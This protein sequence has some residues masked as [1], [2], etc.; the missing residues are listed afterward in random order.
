MKIRSDR[1]TIEVSNENKVLF[2]KSGI[3]K[4]ELVEYYEYIAPIML[5]YCDH[6]LVSMHRFPN[7]IHGENF[8]Q[9]EAGKYFPEWITHVAVPKQTDGTVHYVEIDKPA[10]ILYLANQVC[11]PHIWLSKADNLN[12]PDRLIFDLDP[13]GKNFSFADIQKTAKEITKMLDACGLPSFYMLTGSRGAHIIVPLKRVHTFDETH[14]FAH[15]VAA[16]LAQKF[17]DLM[18]IEMNKKKRGKRIFIDWLRNSFGAT[19]VAPYAVRAHEGA[20]I[21][22]PITW[23]ELISKGMHAQKYTIKNIKKRIN[24]VG[25]IWKGMNK[26]A[27]SLKKARKVL[28]KLIEKENN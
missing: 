19:A 10:T 12:K 20:P 1:Y 3:T 14:D 6:R 8:F 11:T 27:V 9:K 2:G 16:L 23:K 7:G 22:T 28:D 15:D 25:D 21:A 26:K 17:P 24:K 18:T 4:K 5:P 13:S